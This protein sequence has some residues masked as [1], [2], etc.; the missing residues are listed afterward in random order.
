MFIKN[1]RL[2]EKERVASSLGFFSVNNLVQSFK[3]FIRKRDSFGVGNDTR[4]S[5]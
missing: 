3:I 4:R 1:V 2:P 5:H